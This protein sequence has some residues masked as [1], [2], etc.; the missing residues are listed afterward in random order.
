M[1][2]LSVEPKTIVYI[3]D[4]PVNLKV[5]T[6]AIARLP[7]IK[8]LSAMEPEEGIKLI[9]EQNPDL[10]LLDINL[11]IMN[12]FEVFKIL[13]ENPDTAEIPVVA[14]SASAM[15]S[16]M[17]KASQA[18]FNDYVTKPINMAIFYDMLDRHLN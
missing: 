2:T 8:L 17:E 16:D 15:A 10:I 9:N 3:E 4:N 5:V 6:K 18:G 11:P 7:G 12:G 1:N 14:L 13:K